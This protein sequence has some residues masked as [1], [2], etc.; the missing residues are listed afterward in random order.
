MSPETKVKFKE[1]LTQ[2][3]KEE[4]GS[5]W[6]DHIEELNKDDTEWEDIILGSLD[7]IREETQKDKE[8][9]LRVIEEL[10]K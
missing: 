8:E 10:K 4:I 3:I 6:D 1:E 2:R 5:M 7:T 9:V